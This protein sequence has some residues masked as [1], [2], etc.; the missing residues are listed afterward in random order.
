MRR[1]IALLLI[2]SQFAASV[3][4]LTP[5][6]WKEDLA[7]LRHAIAAHPNPFYKAAKEDFDRKAD[8]LAADLGKLQDFEV[9]ARM[10]ELV[11]MLNDGHTRLTMPMVESADLFVGH[12]KTAPPKIQ[13]FG[14]FPI[15]LARTADGLVV[16][17]ASEEHKDLLGALVLR[18][19]EK[20]LAEVESAL[21]P[22]VHGDN[23]YERDYL[24]PDFVVVPELLAAVGIAPNRGNTSWTFRLSNEELISRTLVPV[25]NGAP[26]EWSYL[27]KSSKPPPNERHWFNKLPNGLIYARLT[28]ILNDSKETVAQFAES[29]F[30]E[31][32]ATPRATLVLDLR[33]NP[34]GDNTLNDAIVRAAIRSKKLWEPGRFFVLIN[35]GTFSAASNLTVLL[36]RWTPAIFVGQPTGGAPNG[37]GDPKCTI[38]PNSGLSALVSSLYWQLSTPNDKRDSILPLLFVEPTLTSLRTDQDPAVKLVDSL[39][40]KPISA[41]GNFAGQWAVPGKILKLSFQIKTD[42]TVLTAPDLKIEAQPLGSLKRHNAVLEGSATLGDRTL[43]VHGRLA[44]RHF[45]GWLELAGRPYAFVTELQ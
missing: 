36:E 11:A 39:L 31:I 8:A 14:S 19:E 44:G 45:L 42:K 32:D 16:T 13:P 10:A 40:E 22:L 28:D 41:T 18:I 27:N 33:D 15:R 21:R 43:T 1:L 6:Q 29:L 25:R 2:L 9:V 4:A 30:S 7:V 23:E 35:A 12:A 24:L 5:E 34:G 38:L 17:R 3:R 26:L 37:Y 20:P